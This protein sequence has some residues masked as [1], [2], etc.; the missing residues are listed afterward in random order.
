[1]R[2]FRVTKRFGAIGPLALL[3]SILQFML[4]APFASASS[5]QNQAVLA[6]VG[7]AE[8]GGD[9]LLTKIHEKGRCAIRGHCGKQS[10]FGGELPCLDNG[11]AKEPEKSVR[12]K[13]VGI[14]GKG[15]EE[16]PVCC[17]DEQ[18]SFE[19]R[20]EGFDFGIMVG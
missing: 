4:L 15:W 14:C 13:L 8:S 2:D 1:M 20:G 12:E 18:V 10:F 16:G 6:P 3:L 17:E 5:L 19:G 9:G 11:L 7:E